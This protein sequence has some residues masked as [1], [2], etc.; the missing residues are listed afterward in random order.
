[1]PLQ[2]AVVNPAK[3]KDDP[4]EGTLSD[5]W[6]GWMQDQNDI[7]KKAPIVVGFKSLTLQTAS[8]VSTEIPSS[9]LS[10]GVYRV[11]Y[12]VRV[13]APASVSSS[14]IVSFQWT[15]YGIACSKDF[16]AV[17]GNV[18][19]AVGSDSFLIAVDGA[20]KVSYSTTYAS[21]GIGMTYKLEIILEQVRV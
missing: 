9:V 17:S 10:I 1:M 8:I 21:S 20:T 18:V 19:T 5:A 4:R 2:T 14:I 7:L 3:K 13:T 6:L 12:Y 15:D 16:A 11:S